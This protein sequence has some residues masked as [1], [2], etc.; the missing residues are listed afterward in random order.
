MTPTILVTGK[1]A[2]AREAAIAATLD[3]GSP[4]AVI[5]EGLPA[6]ASG[7]HLLPSPQL[8]IARIAP[9]CPCCSGNLTMR[10]TLNRIL[11]HPPDRLYIG[12]ASS[13]HLHEVRGFL[14]SAPYDRHIRLQ[15]TVSL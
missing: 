9:G 10:V 15:E 3:P 7:P 11:R 8:R 12:L 6:P 14:E 1:D 13:A 2:A 5:L 4:T